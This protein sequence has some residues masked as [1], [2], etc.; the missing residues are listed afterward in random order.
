VLSPGTERAALEFGKQPMA[1][2]AV[3][4]PDLVRR[5]LQKASRDGIVSTIRGVRERMNRPGALG[6]SSAGTVTHVGNRVRDLRVGDRVACAGNQYAYHAEVVYV[7]Q[8]LA[9]RVPETVPFDQAAFATVGAIALQGVRI[10]ELS[11]GDR[12]AVVGMGLVGQLTAQIARAAGAK[13]LA[14][15]LDPRRVEL[16][17]NLGSDIAVLRTEAEAAASRI[18]DGHGVDVVLLTA[19]TPSNDPIQLAATMAR[20]K[21]RVVVVGDVGMAVPRELFYVKELELRL[22]RSYGPGRYDPTYEEAGNDYPYGYVRWTEQRN[23]AAFLELVASGSVHVEPLITHRVPVTSA[24][25][26]YE[27]I[28]ENTA[29][30][31]LGV[32]LSY[33]ASEPV[34]TRITLTTPTAQTTD[35][36][37][38]GVVGA[39]QFARSVL[40]PVMK[41]VPN[42]SLRGV[43]TGSGI[44]A[45]AVGKQFGFHYCASTMDEL[46]GDEDV[47]CIVV[48]TRHNLHAQ[49]VAA[50][51][52]AG[53]DVFV[54]KPLALSN[55]E[56]QAVVRAQQRANRKLMVGFNRRFAPLVVKMREFLARRVGPLVMTY[57]A[58]VSLPPTG[59]KTRQLEEAGSSEKRATLWTCSSTWQAPRPYRCLPRR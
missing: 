2:K 22:S 20:E 43:V 13:V 17:S 19:A 4:H 26:A 28:D 16:A 44:S 40:L 3:H 14:V 35:A 23:L 46:L 30:H 10:S 42:V 52:N 27:L 56:L 39:G 48:A 5:V 9:V 55:E 59:R 25:E 18:S 50:A 33:E 31:S 21:A 7:P 15:D 36:V 41:S 38:V 24:A 51:L 12:V 54:E 37:N 11:V 47:D 8:N 1:G 49:Q 45:A 29:E 58:G 32:L 6:Y 53:K 34:A 57:R